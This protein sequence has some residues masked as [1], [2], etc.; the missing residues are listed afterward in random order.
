MFWSKEGKRFQL[1][2]F[3]R[4]IVNFV[5]VQLTLRALLLP[6]VHSH[7]RLVGLSVWFR[8]WAPFKQER[9]QLVELIVFVIC[10]YTLRKVTLC[11]FWFLTGRCR[12]ARY[13]Q[14]CCRCTIL[15]EMGRQLADILS[16]R[17]VF[18]LFSCLR[19]ST[20]LRSSPFEQFLGFVVLFAFVEIRNS[21]AHN[22]KQVLEPFS[23]CL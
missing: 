10:H 8:F 3:G 5:I 18:S 11:S 21:L 6:I 7:R 9:L 20:S 23:V 4:Y 22:V 17:L 2:Y 14:F 1:V 15:M 12:V 13:L 16:W 19:Y